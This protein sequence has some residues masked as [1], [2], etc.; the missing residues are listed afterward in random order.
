MTTAGVATTYLAPTLSLESWQT[1]AFPVNP[2]GL[3]VNYGAHS[4]RLGL[5]EERAKM[6]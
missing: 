1:Y 5:K 3:E 4:L 2:S 6:R